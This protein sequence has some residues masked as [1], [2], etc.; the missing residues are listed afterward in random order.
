MANKKETFFERLA[1]KNTKDKPVKLKSKKARI[2]TYVTLSV[3]GAVLVVGITV[4]IAVAETKVNY[5]KALT[6]DDK[7]FEFTRGDGSKASIT[8][9]QI[10]E[11]ISSPDDAKKEKAQNEIIKEGIYFLYKQEQ[12]DSLIYQYLINS[13][14]SKTEDKKTNIALEPLEKIIEK[15]SAKISDIK[16]LM[17]KNFGFGKWE[18]EFQKRIAKDY[19][20]AQSETEA[21]NNEVLKTITKDA[22]RRFT[23]ANSSV[24]TVVDWDRKANEDIKELEVV[25]NE[26]REKKEGKVIYK[27]GDFIFR[28]KLLIPVVDFNNIKETENTVIK[29]LNDISTNKVEKISVLLNNSFSLD[30]KVRSI[31]SILT[32]FSKNQKLYASTSALLPGKP[33]LTDTKKDWTITKDELVKLFSLSSIEGLKNDYSLLNMKDGKIEPDSNG[34]SIYAHKNYELF[35]HFF[36][37][38]NLNGKEEKAKRLITILKTFLPKIVSQ[39]PGNLGENSVTDITTL[40]KG[41]EVEETLTLLND[42]LKVVDETQAKDWKTSKLGV[43]LAEM[44]AT[45]E[46]EI[47]KPSQLNDKYRVIKAKFD[48]EQSQPANQRTLTSQ[49]V[50]KAYNKALNDVLSKMTQDKLNS[51]FGS[52]LRKTFYGEDGSKASV[53]YAFK[54]NG[55]IIY[56]VPQKNGISLMNAKAQVSNPVEIYKSMILDE[57]RI[58][59]SDNVLLNYTNTINSWLNSNENIAKLMML[60][61]D[62]ISK[63]LPNFIKT[64]KKLYKIEERDMNKFLDIV[65]IK[66][67]L[68]NKVSGAKLKD[69]IDILKK[70]QEFIKKQ[71]T[72]KQLHNFQV[73][74]NP[75][76]VEFKDGNGNVIFADSILEIL[77]LVAN[78]LRTGGK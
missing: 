30:P 37:N 11:F 41:K 55:K 15:S 16:A 62:N 52:I 44:Q 73:S 47:A 21:I 74:S 5:Q 63:E 54:N 58:Q 72:S 67:V 1:K 29:Y 59:N 38:V 28:N 71:A 34:V 77:K 76:L 46:S 4:P 2:A 19:N 20:N 57:K 49:D 42:K 78:V 66:T 13:S 9:K 70:I 25:N 31:K 64:V 32:S 14:K 45:I 75:L 51:T 8:F 61:N 12:K 39:L 10:Q 35:L 33:D 56:L 23:I 43:A 36:N 24:F 17:K 69:N 48:A 68:E 65:E 27:K 22:L 18:V 3:L 26:V 40:I 7:V 53:Y 50:A 60:N 6:E